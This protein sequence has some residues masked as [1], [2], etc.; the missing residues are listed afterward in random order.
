MKAI[1][2]VGVLLAGLKL[3]TAG[4]PVLL[5]VAVGVAAVLWVGSGAKGAA[6]AGARYVSGH[7]HGLRNFIAKHEGGHAAAAKAVGGRVESAWMTD[8]EGLVMARIPDDP[9]KVVAFLAAG[10][11][12]VNSGR[13]CSA[14]DAAIRQ[15]LRRV[16]SK[17]R[18]QVKRE[19]LRLARRIVSSRSGEIRRFANQLNEK[20]QL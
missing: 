17:E 11:A 4:H 2:A 6:P 18:G 7:A 1:A 19:G 20:G 15:E 16:P 5:L 3:A 13:G 14:D 8:D 12:A 9:V 10:R